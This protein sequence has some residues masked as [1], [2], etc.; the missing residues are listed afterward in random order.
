MDFCCITHFIVL[1][2][3]LSNAKS[4]AIYNDFLTAKESGASLPQHDKQK[5]LQLVSTQT[6][7]RS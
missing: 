5:E 6:N 1:I 4:L 7:Q 2:A 3:L